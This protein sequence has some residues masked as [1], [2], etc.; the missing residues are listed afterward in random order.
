VDTQLGRLKLNSPINSEEYEN[1]KNEKNIDLEL[2]DQKWDPQ[3][4]VI[5]EKLLKKY[6]AITTAK[7][8]GF[9]KGEIRR[10]KQYF[11]NID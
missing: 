8:Q 5:N 7:E 4:D 6:G 10:P 1:L 9:V 11:G 3:T 2:T